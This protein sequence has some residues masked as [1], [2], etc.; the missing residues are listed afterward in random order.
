LLSQKWKEL[1]GKA[2]SKQL[3]P[4]EYNSGLFIVIVVGNLIFVLLEHF[5]PILIVPGC[6]QELLRFQTWVC[7]ELIDLMPYFHQA[8]L[9]IISRIF[10]C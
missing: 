10:N 6:M 1:V 5:N 4:N 2:R 7:S 8:R 3:Q 9:V